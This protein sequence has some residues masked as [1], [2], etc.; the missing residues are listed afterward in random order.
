MKDKI[1]SKSK[2]ILF[3]SIVFLGLIA[4]LFS[5]P[6]LRYPY[7]MIQHLIG[8][9]DIY[10]QLVNPI[11]K[12]VGIWVND[13]YT[14]IPSGK[15]VAIPIPEGRYIWHYLW[16]KVF[17]IVGLKSDAIFLR[18]RMIHIF[19]IYIT[20]FSLYYFTKVIIRNVYTK[21]PSIM[22]K[23]L[24]LWSVVIW[25]TIFATA[26]IRHHQVWIMWYSVNYQITLPLFWYMT[27]LTL[28]LLL[29]EV[30]L[31]KKIFFVLQILLLSR[32]ILQ[33]HSMEFMYYLMYLFVF[34]LV[35]V[36]KLFM[37]LKKHFYIFFPLLG[38]IYYIMRH[39]QP[40]QSKIFYYLS[41]EKL[42]ELYKEILQEGQVLIGGANRA[43]ASVNEL[44]YFI[45][46][47]ALL[48]L[49][50][51][52][53]DKVRR[54][55]M[56]INM[57]MILFISIT[58]LF[59]LIP[60]SQFLGG[61]FGIITKTMVVNRLYYSSSL[62][63]VF[64]IIMY[65]MVKTYNMSLRIMHIIFLIS[66]VSIYIFSKHTTVLQHNYYKNIQSIKNSF[67]ERRVG[68]HLS[69]EEIKMIGKQMKQYETVNITSKKIRYYAR[70]DIA[71]VIKYIYHK[72]VY[73]K[74]RHANPN[75]VKAY[76][77]YK[78]N[79]DYA[80]ILFKTPKDFPRYKPYM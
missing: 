13:I 12:V 44:M 19:Q 80:H 77:Y 64:P 63:V 59:V 24:S 35:F 53:W 16:A 1:F 22:L 62:F 10:M 41:V 2:E 7:D 75:H 18:A 37:Y 25:V 73:W 56:D 47:V 51:L 31:Q 60:L 57:R 49:I 48:F 69:T 50:H 76:Q 70:A 55:H 23:W 38:G 39:Y 6:F 74:G 34:S 66:L 45:G 17:M 15:Y 43:F 67:Y 40:E 14:M 42:P 8:I 36:D 52:V 68:F 3:Y 33:A 46:L 4:I 72:N 58:S 9:D 11:K 5:Y 28:V 54:K 29:E 71:F 79:K 65:Y 27:A 78:N 26:S 30:S 21:I 61:L 32:F 20:L